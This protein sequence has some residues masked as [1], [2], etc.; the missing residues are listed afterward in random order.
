MK[1]A[2]FLIIVFVTATSFGQQLSTADEQYV[3]SIMNFYYKPDAPG[4]VLLIAKNG[5]PVYRKAYGVASLELNVPNKPENVFRI[6]SMSKQFAAVCILKLA[7]EGR[8]NLQD[9]IRKYLPDYNSHGRVITIENIL[10]HTSG[11]ID[12]QNKPDFLKRMR[13]DQS[14]DDLLNS[15][16]PDSLLFEPGTDWHYSNSNYELTGFI[17]EKVSGMALRD[18]LQQ[19]IFQPLEMTHTYVSSD[20][21]IFVNLVNGYDKI[22]GKYRPAIFLSSTWEYAAGDI[23]SNVDDLLKWDNALY[24]DKI[25]KQEWLQKAWKPFLLKNG[26][27]ANYGFAWSSN[28]LNGLQFIEHAGGINGFNSDGIHIPKQHLYIAI[29]SNTTAWW[30]PAV[31]SPIALRI[32]GESLP[33]P[34]S[35]NPD[36]KTLNEYTGVYALQRGGGN[37]SVDTANGQLYSYIILTNDTLFVKLPVYGKVPILPV[38]KDVFVTAWDNPYYRFHRDNKGK[39]ISAQIY[40]QPM[41]TGPAEVRVKTNLPLPKEKKAIQLDIKQLALYKGKYNFGGGAIAAV[42]LDG[43]KIFMQLEDKFEI[44]PEDETHFFFKGSDD[45]VEFVMTNGKVTSAIVTRGGKYEGK[46]VE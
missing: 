32:S 45:T 41:Q 29:L 37:T 27:S 21:S 33:K 7:Q 38:G 44:L 24:T 17:I 15:F 11:I 18:Y 25:V 9:D 3:D 26:V 42:T 19:N 13:T 34:N 10:T 40:N 16:M 36:K 4:A 30:S 12:A 43:D 5:Q 28:T 23:L 39:I 14:H 31:A 1:H 2:F 20:D 8:L 46:K 35:Y 22:A 6:G